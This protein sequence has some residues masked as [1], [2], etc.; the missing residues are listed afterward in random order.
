MKCKVVALWGKSDILP[1]HEV[2]LKTQAILTETALHPKH[3][4]SILEFVIAKLSY[5]GNAQGDLLIA[6]EQILA[7]LTLN[8]FSQM[9]EVRRRDDLAMISKS[10]AIRR[11]ID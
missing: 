8:F 2:K 10:E 7:A 5:D 11:S 1:C 9:V 4:E 6:R 3:W